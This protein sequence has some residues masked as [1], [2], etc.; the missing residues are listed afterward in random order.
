MTT[1]MT[2][3]TYTAM[4]TTT[5]TCNLQRYDAQSLLP[6]NINDDEDDSGH[7]DDDR[8]R[9]CLPA[10]RRDTPTPMTVTTPICANDNH[11][12]AHLQP[13]GT[14]V[15]TATRT[16]GHRHRGTSSTTPTWD[17]RQLSTY[18]R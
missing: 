7:L 16:Y 2:T 15:Q 5:M 13:R 14:T 3:L 17:D 12:D 11:D 18:I 4:T 8:N 1:T 9:C 10:T 6:W